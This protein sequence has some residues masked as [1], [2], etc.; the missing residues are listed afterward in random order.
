MQAGDPT[1]IQASTIRL[2]LYLSKEFWSKISQQYRNFL[3]VYIDTLEQTLQTYLLQ[4][5]DLKMGGEHAFPGIYKVIKDCDCEKLT[6]PMCEG[7]GQWTVQSDFRI[8]SQKDVRPYYF[9][10]TRDSFSFDLHVKEE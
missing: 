2:E 7:C 5:N 9:I 8:W 4:W 1:N 6:M 3:C 10:N